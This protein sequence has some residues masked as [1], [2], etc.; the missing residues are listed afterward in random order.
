MSVRFAGWLLHESSWVFDSPRRN[1]LLFRSYSS[2]LL[3]AGKCLRCSLNIAIVLDPDF[4]GYGSN[5]LVL[6]GCCRFGERWWNCT[7][8][9]A[10]LELK[11]WFLGDSFVLRSFAIDWCTGETSRECPSFFRGI[12]SAAEILRCLPLVQW[13]VGKW[14]WLVPSGHLS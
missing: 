9:G 4:L 13:F 5:S 7:R 8:V 11:E 3:V 1:V 12:G 14:W 2:F 6:V 10:V